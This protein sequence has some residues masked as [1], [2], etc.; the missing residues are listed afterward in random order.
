MHINEEQRQLLSVAAT[1]VRR[2]KVEQ[3]RIDPSRQLRTRF[4]GKTPIFMPMSAYTFVE[5]QSQLGMPIEQAVASSIKPL[6][7]I[8]RTKRRAAPMIRL[9][10]VG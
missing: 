1:K 7:S 6:T 10:E 3:R 2:V 8:K 9:S 5:D 4:Q